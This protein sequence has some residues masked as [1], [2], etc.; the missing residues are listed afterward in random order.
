MQYIISTIGKAKNNDEDIITHKY[1]KRIKNVELKQFEV[2][3][4]SP[5][6]KRD[7]ES[8]KLI[9][10][11]PKNGKLILLDE[12]GENLSSNDLAKIILNWRDNNITNINFA[13]GGAFGNS[14][15]IKKTA[16]RVIA[17]GQLTW[18]HQM[19]KMMVA[20]QIYR[21]ETI[22]QGHPYHK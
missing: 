17:F 4:K 9:N 13:I 3:N 16:D 5:E 19:V 14:E 10:A 20:E 7:N 11:T 1:L 12:K 2:K 22:I 15:K 8:L 21:I 6:K 18:P